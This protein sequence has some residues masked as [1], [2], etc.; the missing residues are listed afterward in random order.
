MNDM[1]TTT[2]DHDLI[3][4]AVTLA[5]RAP[6][7]HNTQ[8]WLWVIDGHRLHLHLDRSR[9]VR[10][11]DTAGREAVIGCGATLDHLRTALAA[12]GWD[13]RVQRFPYPNDVAHLATVELSRAAAISVA[14]L[15]RADAIL[16]RRTDRL[17]LLAPPNW[18]A[19]ESRLR[20]AVPAGTVR[21]DVLA[22]ELRPELTAA[23]A[24][25]DLMQRFNSGYQAELDWWTAPFECA[26][27]VPRS[28][29]TSVHESDRVEV[30][31]SFP[32]EG[33]SARRP[34]IDPDRAKVLI[35]STAMDSYRDALAAGEAL[36]ALLLECTA[37]GLSTCP[38][39]HVT[40]LPAAR[41]VVGELIA[42]AEVP[43][44]LVRV[45][46]A[47]EIDDAAVPTPRRDVDEILRISN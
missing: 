29:L 2:V 25:T 17:P 13:V 43:Q 30:N 47:P 1:P 8:P 40:E 34:G 41:A 4:T 21:L 20:A 5:S 27:G 45:G 37:A 24:L 38:V 7:L 22:E 28:A 46:R 36:S 23:C 14:Q 16:R 6:S 44:V 18:P 39:T 19:I 3:R 33:R 12:A 10:N 26:E 9:I 42:G 11:T 35:L 15:R 31:R 32:V